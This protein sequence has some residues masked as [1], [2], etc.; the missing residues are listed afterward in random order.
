V[1]CAEEG[2]TIRMASQI[3]REIWG[4]EGSRRREWEAGEIADY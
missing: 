2:Q 3:A 4:R 1:Y